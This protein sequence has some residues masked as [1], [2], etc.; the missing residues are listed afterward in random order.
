L[1]YEDENKPENPFPVEGLK[2]EKRLA[3]KFMVALAESSSFF[4][5][6]AKKTSSAP[7][8]IK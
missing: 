6:A 3:K 8:T 2:D 5:L 7:S 1:E 4:A